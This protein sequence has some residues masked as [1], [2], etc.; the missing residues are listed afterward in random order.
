MEPIDNKV[1]G[2]LTGIA[3]LQSDALIINNHKLQDRL[4]AMKMTTLELFK[5][6][7]KMNNHTISGYRNDAEAHMLRLVELIDEYKKGSTD[8]TLFTI[9]LAAG[10]LSVLIQH[11]FELRNEAGLQRICEEL[12]RTKEKTHA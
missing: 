8:H 9:G 11:V 6:Q 1:V 2:I 3:E 10:N 4:K 5:M 7:G 12:E